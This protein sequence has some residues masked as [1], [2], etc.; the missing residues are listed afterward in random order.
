MDKFNLRNIPS[1]QGINKNS[2]SI[3]L[4]CPQ[5]SRAGMLSLSNLENLLKIDAQIIDLSNF[6]DNNTLVVDPS[7]F[8]ISIENRYIPTMFNNQYV[9]SQVISNIGPKNKG[10]NIMVDEN[11]MY[12][13]IEKSNKWKRVLLSD[14]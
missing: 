12:I 11:F 5:W 10:L 3:P 9:T 14:F 1:I 2:T 4:D 13:W 7:T 6:I 8:K